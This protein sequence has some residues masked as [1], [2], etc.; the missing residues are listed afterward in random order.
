MA[1]AADSPIARVGIVRDVQ[2]EL[3]TYEVGTFLTLPKFDNIH[4]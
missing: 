4:L 1:L 3:E 2:T